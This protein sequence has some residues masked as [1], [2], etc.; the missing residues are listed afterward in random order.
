MAVSAEDMARRDALVFEWCRGR[1]VPVCM[2]LSGG[3]AAHSAAAVATSLQALC[4][5]E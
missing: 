2:L 5:S 4:S 3:Y 1:G